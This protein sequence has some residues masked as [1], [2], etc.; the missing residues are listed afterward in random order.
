MEKRKLLPLSLTLLCSL[1]LATACGKPSDNVTN[2]IA[3]V[4]GKNITAENIYNTALYDEATAEYVYGVLEKALIQSSI[5][6]SNSM[7]TK[8]DNEVEKW[9][10]EIEE[11]AAL[12]GTD[13]E[14]DLQTALQEEE[15]GSIDELKQKKIYALQYEYAK[16]K[17][18]DAKS[19][20]YSNLYIN[21]NY[22]YHIG[23]IAIS[24]SS[25]STNT[26]LYN[27]TISASE[28][29]EIY[30]A[31]T[32]LVTGENYY[33]V[34]ERYSSSDTAKD[35]GEVGIVTLNDSDIT[36]EL[37]YALI[38]YSS[39]IEGKYNEFDFPVNDYTKTL[40]DLYNGGIQSIPYSYIKTLD[41]VYSTKDGV[42]TKYM[43]A[44][45]SFYYSSGGNS[46]SSSSK[47]YYRNILFN[48]L[49][50]TKTPKFITVT[51]ED[52]LAGA[53]AI[54]MSNVLMPNVDS[55]GYSSEKTEQ[56][57][58]TNDLGNPYVVFK[59]SQGLHILTI[60]KT[61]F[62]SDVQEYYS[63]SPSS[64]DNIIAYAEFGKYMDARLEEVKSFSEK[65]ITRKYGENTGEDKLLS[66]AMFKYYLEYSGNGNFEITDD[67][68]KKM[69][70]QY[71]TSVNALADTK[72]GSDYKGYYETYSNLVWFRNQD[73]IVK[74]VPLLAC[75]N[76]ESDGNY[77]CI[78]KY[79][80]G[81]KKHTPSTGSEG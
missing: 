50:N 62:E 53:N 17:F 43:D 14:E 49:L 57:V 32:E 77:G 51:E 26:D 40:T 6:A 8:V 27:L 19:E 22:L 33:T 20:E 3:T 18:L 68:V 38:G 21:S 55:A 52:V 29:K 34:A 5:K 24:I 12:N 23:D 64:E 10:K 58:L 66:F 2:V 69:I 44:N 75:L 47:V 46:V 73:Y 74:E 15:V 80:E 65:Y 79:G 59:D 11:N 39:I 7:I 28:A 30:G 1:C 42:D 71:M 41:D 78:Y 16:Q 63:S 13:Y 9:R 61:P 36:N 48:N 31:F 60:N 54:K 76:K 37:R 81:F 35:G 45:N 70:N 56:Y 4:D 72:A 25:S 67:N